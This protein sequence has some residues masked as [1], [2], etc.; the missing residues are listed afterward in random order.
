MYDREFECTRPHKHTNAN[1]RTH[2]RELIIIIC[3]V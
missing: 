3:Y 1:I 2:A